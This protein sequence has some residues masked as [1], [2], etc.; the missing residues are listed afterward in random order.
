MPL[1]TALALSIGA[2]R[3]RSSQ[4]TQRSAFVPSPAP[5]LRA[6]ARVAEQT[7]RFVSLDASGRLTDAATWAAA[8]WAP[9]TTVTVTR[10]ADHL[11]LRTGPGTHAVTLDA[12]GR[13]PLPRALRSCLGWT[14]P[15]TPLI[16][17]SSAGVVVMRSPAVLDLDLNPEL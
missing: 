12:R 4:P 10:S 6:P 9:G 17:T 13:A 14:A 8:G 7:H 3:A 2:N 1:S 11:T 16:A 15:G 5:V